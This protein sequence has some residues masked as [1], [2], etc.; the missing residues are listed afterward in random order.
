[1]LNVYINDDQLL[2][3]WRLVSNVAVYVYHVMG[4][5]NSLSCYIACA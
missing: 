4:K 2:G 5:L 3:M 1:M